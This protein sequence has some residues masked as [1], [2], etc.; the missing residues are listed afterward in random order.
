MSS[1]VLWPPR[2]PQTRHS[3]KAY[4]FSCGPVTCGVAKEL[5]KILKPLVG[6]SPHHINSTP[7]FV[8]QVKHIHFDTWGM[9]QLL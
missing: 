8:E 4:S 2:D 7:D 1:Q 9:S 6:K 3:S 5:A